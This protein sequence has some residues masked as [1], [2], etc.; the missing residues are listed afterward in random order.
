MRRLF[1]GLLIMIPLGVHCA[2]LRFVAGSTLRDKGIY[3]EIPAA[4]Q[5]AVVVSD[6]GF[7]P[8]EVSLVFSVPFDR[9]G[10]LFKEHM[11][12]SPLGVPTVTEITIDPP[13]NLPYPSMQSSKDSS[14]R[15]LEDLRRNNIDISNIRAI[16]F[17]FPVYDRNASGSDYS[18]L[19]IIVADASRLFKISG[20]I[21]VVT[22]VDVTRAY[23]RTF[24][25]GIPIPIKSSTEV[26]LVTSTEIDLLNRFQKDCGETANGAVLT[27]SGGK[28]FWAWQNLQKMKNLLVAR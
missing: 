19:R 3:D 6:V 23:L 4:H 28:P 26:R 10:Q 24:H 18:S 1:F 21:V 15:N 2:D 7:P 20:S 12:T 25:L 27:L 11:K 16:Q 14:S 8:E 17:D 13:A 9:M 22:R 5:E